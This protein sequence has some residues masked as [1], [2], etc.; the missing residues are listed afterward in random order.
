MASMSSVS[1]RPLSR[2]RP[3]WKRSWSASPPAIRTATVIR[4]RSRAASS[5]RFQ[6]SS[7]RT[8]SVISA[9]LAARSPIVRRPPPIWRGCSG[10]ACAPGRRGAVCC[11]VWSVVL[12]VGGGGVLLVGDGLEPG[13]GVRPVGVVLEQREV[14][15]EGVGG[16][17]VP[18][19]L[20]G[21]ADGGVAGADAQHGAVAG[22]DEADALADVQGLADG[23]D[24]PV[25]AGP[26]SEAHQGG[27]HP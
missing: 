8:S 23:G 21:R 11:W 10:M 13:R 24:V 4:L 3:R 19:L 17:A 26:R 27:G 9:S 14:A 22:A 2:A 1:V 16:G 5:V 20:P 25:A 15:H 18:V 7:N 6:T 12:G